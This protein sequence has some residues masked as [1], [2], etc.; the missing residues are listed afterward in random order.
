METV[1]RGGVLAMTGAGPV[2]GACRVGG[3]T[4]VAGTVGAGSWGA[5]IVVEV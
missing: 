4:L 5:K 2:E 3:L 1:V